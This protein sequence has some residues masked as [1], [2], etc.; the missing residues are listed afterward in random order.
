MA[1]SSS[2]ALDVRSAL[3]RAKRKIFSLQQQLQEETSSESREEFSPSSWTPSKELR[4][5]LVDMYKANPRVNVELRQCLPSPVRPQ[6]SD[7]TLQLS[8]LPPQHSSPE[9]SGS[10][11]SLDH[12]D[13]PQAPQH[14]Q[15]SPTLGSPSPV[16]QRFLSPPV[17]PAVQR[18]SLST[19]FSPLSQRRC[20][21]PGFSKLVGGAPVMEVDLL[22]SRDPSPLA[23]NC[24]EEHD[25]GRAPRGPGSPVIRR[26][27]VITDK[28]SHPAETSVPAAASGLVQTLDHDKNISFL[29]KELDALRE[30]NT[31]LQAQLVQKEKEL[32]RRALEEGMREEQQEAKLWERPS[33]VLEELLAAQKD[34]DQA[35]MSRLLLANE[36]RDE[37]LLRA[38][39]LQQTAAI[40]LDS[41]N[42]L[43]TDMNVDELLQCVCRADSVQEVEQFGSVL[44]QRLR[45][46]RQRRNDITAQEMQAVIEER[47]NSVSKCKR[48][49]QDLQEREKGSYKEELQR[50]QRERDSALQ[51]G[52][53]LEMELQAL[54]SNHSPQNLHSSQ[55]SRPSAPASSVDSQEA[56]VLLIQLQQLSREKKTVE[57]KLERCQE[58]EREA[59]E[60]VHR[61]ERLVEVLRKKVGAGNL[62]AVI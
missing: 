56:R 9:R 31:R 17:S 1:S 57:A 6:I 40:E 10:C 48:L 51:E 47:D 22:C 60:Q 27:L 61:L 59:C 8:R 11:V 24:S 38:R 20:V 7:A 34:R 3:Q 37:A 4:E 54:R 19:P 14:L 35:L 33:A 32:E 36:E 30:L 44:V 58:A 50:L 42:E 52:Q 41:G 18:R 21:S 13:W 16:S 45:L 55:E 5:S 26:H 15:E 49:E 28:S 12:V 46:A 53:Q 23:E 43:D 62:R 25:G 29:L 2:K 39:H